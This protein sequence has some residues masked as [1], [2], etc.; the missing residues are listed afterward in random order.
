MDEV[1]ADKQEG[2]NFNT[3]VQTP[4]GASQFVSGT[5]SS[6]IYAEGDETGEPIVG[7]Q[8]FSAVQS[9]IES[10]LDS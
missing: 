9:V 7:A 3:V 6:V 2:R 4:Q 10:K 8:P 1:N 5:P